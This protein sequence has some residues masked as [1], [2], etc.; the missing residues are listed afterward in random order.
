M[1]YRHLGQI[2]A[3]APAGPGPTL[4]PTLTMTPKVSSSPPTITSAPTKVGT[5]A[6]VYAPLSVQPATTMRMTAPV[7][8]ASPIP[9]NV[10]PNVRFILESALKYKPAAPG[11]FVALV[12]AGALKRL[13]TEYQQKLRTTMTAAAL[14]AGLSKDIAVMA[15]ELT[16][17]A[18]DSK[19]DYYLRLEANVQAKALAE[20]AP[21][22][23]APTATKIPSISLVPR[24]TTPTK[25][26]TAPT[27]PSA[28]TLTLPGFTPAP[29][30]TP[31][32]SFQPPTSSPT[33]YP[34]APAPDQTWAPQ[35]GYMPG[36]GIVPMDSA[37][38]SMPSIDTSLSPA[39]YFA[40]PPDSGLLPPE[41]APAIAIP[42]TTTTEE[43]WHKKVPLWAW[44]GGG[45]VVVGGIVF[46]ATRHKKPVTPNRRRRR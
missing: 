23:P 16:T 19:V 22:P 42:S 1:S 13:P 45:A 30:P 28:P 7:V 11:Q 35:P 36:D 29:M 33:V 12:I 18:A 38:S 27:A 5:P 39:D 46:V 17:L 24:T 34:E 40:L 3:P 10:S 15:R 2:L 26:V 41:A 21:P 14:R 25:P 31:D 8:A 44:V 37:T 43:P 9:S 4:S 6:P 20:A 32:Q